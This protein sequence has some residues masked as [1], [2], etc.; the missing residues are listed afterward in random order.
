MGLN[1]RTTYACRI[2]KKI[3]EGHSL[4]SLFASHR[5]WEKRQPIVKAALQRHKQ[6]D[7]WDLLIHAAKIDRMIKGAEVGDVWTELKN[8]A[9]RLSHGSSSPPPERVLRGERG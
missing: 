2:T 1:T 5:I 8:L 4:S 9:I 3:A 6:R 7:F